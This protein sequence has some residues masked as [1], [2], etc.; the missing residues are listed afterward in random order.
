MTHRDPNVGYDIVPRSRTTYPR[1]NEDFADLPR[2]I[3]EFILD[4]LAFPIRPETRI[5]LQGSCFAENLYNELK[6]QE[7]D[8]FYNQFVEAMNSPLANLRY[9]ESLGAAD[10]VLEHLRTADVFVLT[11]GVAPCWFERATGN[12]TL[13]PDLRRIGDYEQRTLS[14][15]ESSA[16]LAG[17]FDVLRR[18]NPAL[19][20][21]ITLSPVPLART[22]EF[23]SA[24]VADCV[25]KCTLRAA[26]HETLAKYPGRK[27]VY[28]PAFEIV[29][30]VGAHAGNAFGDD[31]LPRHIS[32]DYVRN[33]IASFLRS[34]APQ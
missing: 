14:V 30:W 24:I 23:S 21:V 8:C 17:V 5:F 34:G 25:S 15:A 10:P 11:I 22:F 33:I 13:Q 31:G 1:T 27:P 29:R 18:I 12:F 32:R 26:I 6:R 2:C 28:F 9:F 20:I 4:P 16:A 19:E 7:R 3:A